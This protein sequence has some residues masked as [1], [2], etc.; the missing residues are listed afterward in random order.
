MTIE[1]TKPLVRNKSASITYRHG[2]LEDSYTVFHIFELTLAD[3]LKQ[4]GSTEPA[5]AADPA[6]LQRMWQER[7]SLYEHLAR[8][9]EHFWL[10]ESDG[11][12][13]GF[14]RSINRDGVRQL[15]EYFVLPSAQ[16]AGIG[17]Q[18]FQHAFPL[19]GARHLSIL[20]TTDLRA[21]VRYLKAGVYPRFP[22]YYFGRQPEQVP[23]ETDLEFK[24]FDASSLELNGLSEIDRLILGYRRDQDHLW[25]STD[26]QG[27]GYYRDE[28]LVG[29]GYTGLRNGPFA[30]L[31]SADYPAVLAHA[32]SLSAQAGYQHFGLEIPMVNQTAVDYLLRRGF[33]MDNFI[34]LLMNDQPFG[35][36]Q[37]YIVTSPPF[38][39]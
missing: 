38:F 1:S 26:R 35:Q 27:Y 23:V 31:E 29:Y 5:S 16:S 20:T 17:R 22:L 8:T 18:L 21:Q 33:R 4:L 30:L 34:A 37:N 6:A 11:E 19:E 2:T 9:A 28:G 7:R 3:M 36:F 12:A 39:L 24:P 13:L 15:T 25:L 32:E 10:A 14:A